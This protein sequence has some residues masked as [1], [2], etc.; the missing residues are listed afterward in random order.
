MRVILFIAS[1]DFTRTKQNENTGSK[2]PIKYISH[3]CTSA[4]CWGL[5]T[6]FLVR[7]FPSHFLYGYL[8]NLL[9]CY[10]THHPYGSRV[11]KRTTALPVAL[12][13]TASNPTNKPTN[14]IHSAISPFYVNTLLQLLDEFPPIE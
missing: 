6:F 7:S 1:N 2:V 4:I 3:V 8:Y 10:L 5:V 14:L 9:S 12:L 11:K 13:K